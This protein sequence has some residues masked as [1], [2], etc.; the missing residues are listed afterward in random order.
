M[1]AFGG[2]ERLAAMI[3][4]RLDPLRFERFF[5]ATHRRLPGPTFEGELVSAGVRT[6]AL[7]RGSK[8][9]LWAWW[10]LISLLRRERIDI[11][12]CHKFSANIW[13]AIV[14]SLAR[15]PVLIAHEHAGSYEGQR[16]RRFLDRHLVARQARAFLTVSERTRGRMIRV[17]GVPPH[18]VRVI[19]NGIPELPPLRGTHLRRELGISEKSPLIGMVSQLRTEKR[20]DLLIAALPL[21]LREFPDLVAVV[22]G[23]GPEEA[24]LRELIQEQHLDQKIVLLGPRVDI[25]DVLA[26]ID[27]AVSSSDFEGSPLAIMEYMAAGKPIVATSVGGVPE[28]VADGVHA[29]LVE[30]RNVEGLAAAIGRLL[31]DRELGE[32]LGEAARD[33]Q[34]REFAIDVMV[35][36]LEALYVELFAATDRARREL[37]SQADAQQAL[38]WGR[39]S[40]DEAA[41]QSDVRAPEALETPPEIENKG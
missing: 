26:A 1:S 3:S 12:H 5:C 32:R 15:V 39:G 28:L 19:P 18:V 38:D 34:Q 11:V 10:P 21:L 4:T 37:S 31:R 40:G 30:P 25:S 7:E 6:L 9:Q 23:R 35:R 27:V 24:R 8:A 33:R 14:G 41:G 17:D 16:L 22:A 20:I 36:R 13:G 2:A 29:L